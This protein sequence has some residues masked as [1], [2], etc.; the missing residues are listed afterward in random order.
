LIQDG[1]V[2]DFSAVPISSGQFDVKEAFA[3][4]NA[5]LLADLPF[6]NLLSVSA[7]LRLS[8]YSTIGRTTT[9]KVDGIY[10]PIPDIRFR[11]TYSQAVR[12]PNI[13]ELFE[14]R[15]GTFLFVTDPCDVT[16]LNDGTSFRTANCATILSGLGLSPAQIAAFSPST[17]AQNTTSRSGL[18]GGNPN[19]REESARTWTAGVVLKPGFIPG[20]TLTADWYNI[21]I[22]GAVNTPTP[23]EVAE[24]CVD[25]PTVVNE[26]CPNIFRATGTGFVLGDS[27][28]LQRRI[29]FIVGPSNVAAF[30]TSGADFS[31]TYRFSP[32]EKLGK[33]V[34]SLVGGY[35]NSIDFTPTLGADV[36]DDYLE[37]YNPRWRGSA[38]LDWTL[39]GFNASYS[40]DYFSKTRRFTTEQL[41]ANPDLSDPA[42]F[43]FNEK[44]THDARVSYDIGEKFNVYGGVNNIFDAKP[45]FT[46]LSYPVSGV[47]RSMYIGASIKM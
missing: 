28:D 33:F 5:P 44:W 17:D 8:D 24:L 15:G 23:T 40:V 27:N 25:Q 4:L 22:S 30:R 1:A 10:S 3:E 14:P 21:K 2:R 45:D 19:L 12:A 37:A 26:Y 7:A 43:I 47:G 31:L 36:D 6:V 38:T 29:G 41:T 9:W 35:L 39:N 32:S 16:R 20:L 42:F 46:S 13:G 11:G 34:F 18:S